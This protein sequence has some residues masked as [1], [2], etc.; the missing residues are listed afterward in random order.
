MLSALH[1]S[2]TR[3]GEPVLA[4]M[5]AVRQAGLQG[6]ELKRDDAG[7]LGPG[8]SQRDCADLRAAA[9]KLGIR[10]VGLSGDWSDLADLAPPDLPARQRLLCD[11]RAAMLRASWLGAGAL[12][13]VPAVLARHSDS[14]P[15]IGYAEAWRSTLETL[16]LLRADAEELGV[17]L[18]LDRAGTRFLLSPIEAA[19]L[20]DQANSSAIGWYLDPADVA[21]FG[22]PQDWIRTLAGRIV[23]VRVRRPDARRGAGGVALPARNDDVDWPGAMAALRHVGYDGPLTYE[24]DGS[25]NEIRSFM[26]GLVTGARSI[27]RSTADETDGL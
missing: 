11:L 15:R 23:R 8:A 20:V 1:L 25:L 12:R 7:G 3:T 22:C 18:A 14:A 6:V 21:T 19:E 26:E 2:G 24:G 4:Q 13:V 10:I 9:E 5:T 27:A 17:V 16:L